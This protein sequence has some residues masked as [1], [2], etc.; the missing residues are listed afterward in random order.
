VPYGLYMAYGFISAPLAEQTGFGDEDLRLLWEA[1]MSMFEH[2]HSAARGHMAT[3]GLYVF[4]HDSKLGNAPA[5]A[6]FECIQPVLRNGHSVPRSFADYTVTVQD[7]KLPESV[8]L[9]R[10][11]G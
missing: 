3:R 9:L 8:T 1:L 10:L 4:K 5:H 2:D 7:Q 11:V 6:L